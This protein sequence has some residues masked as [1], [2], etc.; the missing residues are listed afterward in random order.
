MAT[1]QEL[2]DLR[3][4]SSLLNKIT[5]AIAIKCQAI[6]DDE[7]ATAGQ[8]VWARESIQKPEILKT[9][10]IWSVL[11]ANKEVSVTNIKNATDSAYQNNVNNAINSLI[12][13]LI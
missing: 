1:Y 2:F 11:I 6:I 3:N 5:T 9:A 7:A 12:E 8:K 13:D 4:D 10:I